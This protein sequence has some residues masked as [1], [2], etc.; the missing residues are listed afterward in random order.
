MNRPRKKT[1][2]LLIAAIA[3]AALY[4]VYTKVHSHII[5]GLRDDFAHAVKYDTPVPGIPGIRAEQCGACHREIYEEW[6]TS[7]HSK[8]YVDPFFQA[9]WNKD[10]HIWICLNCHSPMEPQQPQKI[11][12]L[13]DGKVHLPITADNPAYDPEFQR[14]GIT[15]AS[16][17][18]RDGVI[19]GPF[20]GLE[21]PH[22]T[23]YSPRFRTT[24]ICFTCHQVPSGPLQFYNGGPCSTFPEFEAGPYAKKGMI[25]QDCHMPPINRPLVAGGTPRDGRQHLWR[26]GHFPEMVQRAVGVEVAQPPVF[27]PGRPFDLTLTMTNAG[28]GHKIPT[29]DPDRFF[30]IEFE[31][32]DRTGRVVDEQSD[33]MRRWIVWWPVIIE[34]YENRLAPLASRDYHYSNK[35]P[36]NPVGMKLVAR[37]RYHIMTPGQYRRLQTKFGL[38][39]EVPYDY[40]VWEQQWPLDGKPVASLTTVPAAKPGCGLNNPHTQSMESRRG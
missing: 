15:C 17:H 16:C 9:Y 18:V 40:T 36:S 20:E 11:L 10:Q 39:E 5:F 8:A 14:E 28:A 2:L 31:L 37:V 26:G 1:K 29:G 24:Q 7:Y 12:G 27:V 6:K 21:A 33:S 32:R 13:K 35:V 3:G 22:P 19:E 4:L 23:R 25:C 30:T 38:K 34:L